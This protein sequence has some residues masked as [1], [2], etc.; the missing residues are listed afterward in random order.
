MSFWTFLNF[1]R[2][3]IIMK[4]MKTR[5]T[6]I[7]MAVAI[8]SWVLEACIFIM[9]QTAV[10]GAAKTILIIMTLVIWTF[11]MSFVVLVIRLAVENLFISASEKDSTFW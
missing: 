9:A 1:G 8:V 2:T 7:E 5:R 3:V 4:M 6:T 10:T 11:W